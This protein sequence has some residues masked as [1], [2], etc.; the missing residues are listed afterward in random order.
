[1]T[2]SKFITKINKFSKEI[3]LG[4]VYLHYKTLHNLFYFEIYLLLY[5]STL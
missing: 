2:R 3:D 4:M 5:L 1:M